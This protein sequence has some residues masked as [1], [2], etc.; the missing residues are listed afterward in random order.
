VTECHAS[1]STNYMETSQAVD[2]DWENL[3]FGLV[4]T[5]FMYVA[6][7]GPDGNFSKGEVLPFGPIAV[8]PSA[9]VLNYGQGLFEGLKAYRKTDG[10]ILLFHPEENATRMITGADRMCMPAPTVEQF[11]DA[12]KQTVL[13]NKRWVCN[14][15]SL[16]FHI[17]SIILVILMSHCL[18]H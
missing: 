11:V 13:A 9:G 8:S 5:D 3:G 18:I 10:S 1:L 16:C 6:K 17:Y 7:C 15:V 4:E 12:V 2:L 14:Y